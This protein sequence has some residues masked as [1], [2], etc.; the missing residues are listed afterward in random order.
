MKR[1]GR[2]RQ[3]VVAGLVALLILLGQGLSLS[4][5]IGGER[6]SRS[7]APSSGH[8][9]ESPAGSQI[10]QITTPNVGR[11]QVNETLCVQT[12]I[13]RPGN[14]SG[15]CDHLVYPSSATYDEA[16]GDIYLSDG[17][18]DHTY[19]VSGATNKVVKTITVGTAAWGA[20]Y[21]PRNG[22]VYVANSASNNVSVINGSA[23][24]I[25]AD[26]SLGVSPWSATCDDGNG[27]IYVADIYANEVSV[28]SGTND[29]VIAT[30]P[31]GSDPDGAVYDARNGNIYV[32][33]QGAGPVYTGSVS[34]INGSSN[35]VVA[36]VGVGSWPYG[37][38]YDEQN[39][40]VYVTNAWSDNVS[41]ISG[42]SN[43]VVESIP[44]GGWPAGA[45]YD[46]WNEY[47][48]VALEVSNEVSVI[49]GATNAIV[50]TIHLGENPYDPT[51]DPENNLTYVPD[52]GSASIS[53]LGTNY[54]VENMAFSVN[55]T[56][57][58]L[59]SGTVWSV[60]ANGSTNSTAASTLTFYLP[61]G[62]YVFAV[63]APSQY[64]ADPSS[65]TVVVSGRSP[66][67]VEIEFKKTQTPS[68]FLGFAGD[69]G[70]IILGLAG[71]LAIAV[72]ATL[73]LRRRASAADSKAISEK[74]AEEEATGTTGSVKAKGSQGSKR[75][76]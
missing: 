40:E 33:N 52:E 74:P 44:T 63:Y 60:I 70:Y 71:A 9:K 64:S 27:D 49:S 26:V 30:I 41:V 35:K 57:S 11:I 12:N 48:Y 22:F 36:T 61:N 72:V 23:Q 16:N 42:S 7:A 39:G 29:S 8:V 76:L 5:S 6:S 65:G 4:P 14:D 2:V 51:Y 10:Q 24:S 50:T 59:P 73:L 21:D 31:V 28:I 17:V 37:G 20:T 15:A 34:V 67:P 55:F 53:I 3:V 75:G 47:V 66:M 62:S 18:L 25:V 56:E 45:S 38:A 46:S 69:T 54:S 1:S 58:G 68:T 43:R 32:T 13:L 19:V